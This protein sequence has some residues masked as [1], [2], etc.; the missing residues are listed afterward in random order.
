MLNS[1]NSKQKI[2]QLQ[3]SIMVLNVIAHDIRKKKMNYQNADNSLLKMTEI[4]KKL[5][6]GNTADS[7]M[8]DDI[9]NCT[10]V[11]GNEI[12]A[13]HSSSK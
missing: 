12:V 10:N 2:L 1:I 6:T 8:E 7:P 11:D 9:N 4:L 5:I 3:T 13:H